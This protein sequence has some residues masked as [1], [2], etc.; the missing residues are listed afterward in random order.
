MPA[1]DTHFH[2]GRS[3]KQSFGFGQ[4]HLSQDVVIK[5][6]FHDPYS[7]NGCFLK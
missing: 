2:I 1:R 6:F 7:T 3:E 5:V 4:D